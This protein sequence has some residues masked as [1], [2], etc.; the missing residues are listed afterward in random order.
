[1][2]AVSGHPA[3][4]DCLFHYTSAVGLTGI[5]KQQCIRATDSAFLNDSLEISFGAIA[6]QRHLDNW[7]REIELTP[8]TSG[9]DEWHRLQHLYAVVDILEKFNDV[10]ECAPTTVPTQLLDGATYVACFTEQPDQL[11]QWRG[12]GGQGYSIGFTRDGL[13]GKLI[14]DGLPSTLS[15]SSI[16]RVMYGK[17][18]HFHPMNHAAIV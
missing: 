11:S 3:V 15:P 10:E 12:Y 13:D 5:L 16:T 18:L 7:I 1:M 14:V 6:V 4:E 8:P 9:S 2:T 17:S